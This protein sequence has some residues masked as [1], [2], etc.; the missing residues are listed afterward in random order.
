M[1]RNCSERVGGSGSAGCAP[2]R[3]ATGAPLAVL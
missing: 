1:T 2:A 3:A